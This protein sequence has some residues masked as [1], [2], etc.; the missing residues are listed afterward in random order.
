VDAVGAVVGA[1]ASDAIAEGAGAT[2]STEADAVARG[3]SMATPAAEGVGLFGARVNTTRS[4]TRNSAMDPAMPARR[5]RF[6]RNASCARDGREGVWVIADAELGVR[7][8]LDRPV[9]E[10]PI[11]ETLDDVSE[12]VGTDGGGSDVGS[13]LASLS[14]RATRLARFWMSSCALS[15][16]QSTT[17]LLVTGGTA[18]SSA[19]AIAFAVS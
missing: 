13:Q 16:T 7:L 10:L 19:L 14:T 5:R 17:A 1:A 18:L 3:G 11:N 9:R 8:P 12:S 15:S 2:G 6:G 4:T